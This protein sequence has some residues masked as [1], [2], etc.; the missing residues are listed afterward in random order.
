MYKD[1]KAKNQ[2]EIVCKIALRVKFQQF[3]F[4]TFLSEKK[5]GAI[6]KTRGTWSTFQ[7]V[8]VFSAN[9]PCTYY[10]HRH[11][12]ARMYPDL[13]CPPPLKIPLGGMAW[14]VGVWGGGWWSSI[15]LGFIDLTVKLR[16]W[17]IMSLWLQFENWL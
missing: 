16:R 10:V 11:L 5:S 13:F 7:S 8:S 9:I 4:L 1:R 2:I 14:G 6:K 17:D 12:R 15:K 3:H